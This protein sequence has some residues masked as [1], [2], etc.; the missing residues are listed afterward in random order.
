MRF[1]ATHAQIRSAVLTVGLAVLAVVAARPDLAGLMVPFVAHLAWGL[2]NHPRWAGRGESSVGVRN[3]SVVIPEGGAVPVTV[4]ATHPWRRALVAAQLPVRPGL[5]F[6]PDTGAVLSV[7]DATVTVEPDRWGRYQL[8]GATVSVR[9]P[10]GSWQ[11]HTTTDPLSITVRPASSTLDGGSGVAHPIGI[12]GA[13]RS[14]YRGDGS[15]L[16]DVREFRTGD[17]LRRINWRVTSRLGQVHVNSTLT[18]RDTDVLIVADTLLDIATADGATNLDATVRAVA[19]ISRHYVG[20][21]D[22]VAVHDLGY[23]IGHVPPGS[24]PRQARVVTNILSRANRDARDRYQIRR[25]PKV[26]SG[27]LVFFCSP[28]LERE[29]QDELVRLRRLGAEVVGVDTLPEGLGELADAAS[30]GRDSYLGEAWTIRRIERDHALARLRAL[31][32]PVTAWRGTGS[33]GSVLLSMEAARS[34]PR[35]V[36]G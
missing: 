15:D 33:L 13:H 30:F 31:G 6:D 1:A 21:G 12:V 7:D 16:A 20:F 3:R 28:L 8:D 2:W 25:V 27:T 9:D 18:E 32:I 17:R 5:S 35:R 22:R 4:R 36:V 24:G 26:T 14:R 11:A 10:S 29:T 23:R 19:A 34:A